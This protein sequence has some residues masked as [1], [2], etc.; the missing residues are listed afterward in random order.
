MC[1]YTCTH[2]FVHFF[3]YYV[4]FDRGWNEEKVVYFKDNYGVNLA[5]I[6]KPEPWLPLMHM[7]AWKEFLQSSSPSKCP[8]TTSLFL[9]WITQRTRSN[10]FLLRSAWSVKAGGEGSLYLSFWWNHPNC[11]LLQETNLSNWLQPE[12]WNTL[13]LIRRR[14]TNPLNPSH[15]LYLTFN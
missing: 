9:V 10:L 2:L 14:N 3:Y 6:K 15:L 5:V 12:L 4:S 8:S 13:R 7:W 1:A 11:S